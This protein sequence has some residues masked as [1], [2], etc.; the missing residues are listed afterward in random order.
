MVIAWGTSHSH[1]MSSCPTTISTVQGGTEALL[2][3][4]SSILRLPRS[5]QAAWL[6]HR[7]REGW[8]DGCLGRQLLS[9][10]VS[11]GTE[12]W[13]RWPPPCHGPRACTSRTWINHVL[14]SRLVLELW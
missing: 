6:Q 5:G 14:Y 9:L 1:P 4:Q 7:G 12:G 3:H 2:A 11:P 8:V 10:R 13:E